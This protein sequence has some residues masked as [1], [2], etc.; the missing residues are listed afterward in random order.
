[1][2][3]LKKLYDE[4]SELTDEDLVNDYKDK[5]TTINDTFNDNTSDEEFHLMNQAEDMLLIAEQHFN[6]IA[7]QKQFDQERDERKY[8]GSRHLS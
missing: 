4:I 7:L 1:M 2:K 3:Q 8:E 5:L 6:S